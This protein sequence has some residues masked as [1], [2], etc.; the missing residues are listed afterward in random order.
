MSGN[1]EVDYHSYKYTGG[2]TNYQRYLSDRSYVNDPQY[3]VMI[4]L[5]NGDDSTTP[6]QY[7]SFLYFL[8]FKYSASSLF[9][10]NFLMDHSYQYYV[11][12]Y[13]FQMFKEYLNNPSPFLSNPDFRSALEYWSANPNDPNVAYFNRKFFPLM[14]ELPLIYI[15]QYVANDPSYPDAINNPRNNMSLESKEGKFRPLWL[16]PILRRSDLAPSVENINVLRRYENGLPVEFWGTLTREE[17]T[18]KIKELPQYAEWNTRFSNLYV[19]RFGGSNATLVSGKVPCRWVKQRKNPTTGQYE[20][21]TNIFRAYS[22]GSPQ[23]GDVNHRRYELTYGM[24][25]LVMADK[26]QRA[27]I[28]DIALETVYYDDLMKLINDSIFQNDVGYS[29]TTSVLVPLTVIEMI[30]R[31]TDEHEFDSVRIP[32]HIYDNDQWKSI[33]SFIRHIRSEFLSRIG[34]TT[35]NV[36]QYVILIWAL[37]SKFLYP[38]NYNVYNFWNENFEDA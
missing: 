4:N 16:N 30:L 7:S 26:D 19:V 14:V 27:D 23:S 33:R 15:T 10:R 34:G 35:I 6:N 5:L 36:L 31:S 25:D 29:E 13:I 12:W 22:S 21:E 24:F 11:L 9:D 20:D 32:T 1:S 28:A 3:S 18:I 38:T 8:K 2:G 17:G 37:F